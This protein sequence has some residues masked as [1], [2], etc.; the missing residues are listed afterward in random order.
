MKYAQCPSQVALLSVI[1]LGA[2]AQPSSATP[3]R[4]HW[5]ECVLPS[6]FPRPPREGPCAPFTDVPI[7]VIDAIS[8]DAFGEGDA[9]T[10]IAVLDDGSAV[11]ATMREGLFRVSGRRIATLFQ[12][13]DLCGSKPHI[14]ELLGAFDDQAVIRYEYTSVAGVRADASISFRWSPQGG[15]SGY[16]RRIV[17]RDARGTLWAYED[18]DEE[19]QVL[20]Y[21]PRTRTQVRIDQPKDVSY[22]FL[23]PAGKLY[24]SSSRGLFEVSAQPHARVSLVRGPIRAKIGPVLIQEVGWDGSIWGATPSEVMHEHPNGK[25]VVFRLSRAGIG[26]ENG[27]PDLSSEPVSLTMGPDGSVWLTNPEGELF[28][29]TNDDRIQRILAPPQS[30]WGSDPSFARDGSL[31]AQLGDGISHFTLTRFDSS[32]ATLSPLSARRDYRTDYFS[33]DTASPRPPRQDMR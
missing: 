29:F 32:S 17:G 21:D 20:A 33:C 15:F 4:V 14:L 7:H 28:R 5:G 1:L 31:W 11:V 27:V 9:P 2:G 19:N 23:S 18:L 10:A 24:A 16:P 3:A 13:N 26:V 22:F 30:S 25:V 12:P 8:F 6:S